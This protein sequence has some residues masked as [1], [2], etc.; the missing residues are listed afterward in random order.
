[1]TVKLA[2]VIG[3]PIAQSKSPL[4]HNYWLREHAIAGLYAPFHVTEQN[5]DRWLSAAVDLGV[6]GFNVTKPH[7]ERLA[8]RV[9]TLKPAAAAS[10]SV[11]T[12]II[13]PSGA[14]IGDST[15]GVGFLES[16]RAAGAPIELGARV[17][18][19]GAGGAARSVVVAMAEAG[20]SEIRIANRTQARAETLVE[21]A[22]G[23][24]RVFDWPPPATFY[25]DLDLLANAT[26]LG[27]A[28][29]PPFDVALPA[30]P[31]GLVATDMIYAPLETPFLKAAA[32]Q[33]A[34][35]VDGLGMLLHQAAPG[36]E[37][38]FGVRPSVTAELR[39]IVLARTGFVP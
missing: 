19:L 5:L 26:S 27:M 22:E 30:L 35:M 2:G 25:E 29:Q 18:L 14:L 13:E 16:L 7:K 9:H 37:A 6:V 28:G 8:E 21:A 3:D 39:Q 36:F 10:G 4:I 33:G 12:V 38:W 34:Q 32:A 23:V 15:D 20:A 31:T 17:G 11:N 1:M 24:A